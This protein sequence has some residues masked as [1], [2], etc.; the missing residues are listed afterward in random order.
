[1]VRYTA[2]I[3]FLKLLAYVNCQNLKNLLHSDLSAIFQV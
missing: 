2:A 1:M 3:Q